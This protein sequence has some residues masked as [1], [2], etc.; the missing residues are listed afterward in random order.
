MTDYLDKLVSKLVNKET[1]VSYQ[2]EIIDFYKIF[3]KK[4]SKILI[5]KFVRPIPKSHAYYHRLGKEF[6]L[7]ISKKFAK[8]FLQV[9][10][11]L[12]ISD[13]IPHIIR[14]SAGCSLVCYLLGITDI[15]PIKYNIS[16][17]RFMHEG[18]EDLPDV[19]IDFPH[20]QRDDIYNK[21]FEQ[22]K[23]RVAR[24]SNHIYYKNKSA[25]KEAIR[26]KGYNKFLPRDVN[27]DKIFPDKEDQNDVLQ[28]AEELEG[29]FRCHSLHCGGIIIFDKEVPKEYY[30]KDFIIKEVSDKKI[31]GSQ[32]KL[33]K[34][35]VEDMNLIKIDI[36][37]NRGLSQ[38]WD[39]EKKEIIKY[40]Y[41]SKVYEYLHEGNNL[42]I[43]YSESRGLRKLFMEIKPKTIDDIACILALIRPAA[44]GGGQKKEFIKQCEFFIPQD[45]YDYVIYDDDA[46]RIISKLLNVD[47]GDADIY[48]K[49]FS[50]RNFKIKADFERKLRERNKD[51]SNEEVE[52]IMYKLSQLEDYSFCKSHAIS[53][54]LLV[55]ALAY[56]K[57]YNPKRFWLATLNNCNS[58]YR[59][60]VHYREAKAAGIRLSLGSPPWKLKDDKLY[61]KTMENKLKYDAISN[62]F[63]Y[64][65]WI[66]DDF[67]PG[68][69][70]RVESCIRT[71]SKK[72]ENYNYA[73]F[74]GIIGTYRT[75]IPQKGMKG[76]TLVEGEDISKTKKR[77]ITFVTLGYEDGKYVD[78][79]LW[80]NHN[81]HKIHCIE[82]EG[83][84]IDEKNQKNQWIS[85]SKFKYSYIS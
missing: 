48:R 8:V 21:I 6:K 60:W 9:R 15:D 52:K 41:D 23:G 75:Y 7:I 62:Y 32:I 18:R 28:K 46:I 10:D 66:N 3:G 64:G 22:W 85:A 43:T 70:L 54:A 12:E 17:A 50:K 72:K 19:D 73:Y 69:Y 34:D 67:L 83:E 79:V 44:S 47:E 16:L 55:Y 71:K 20:N 57:Y 56:Q 30:L 4:T 42:G 58:S 13:G 78:I 29:T 84:Y 39:I 45:Q 33:N 77:M 53:Y 49:G 38:L 24:I 74:R 35:E 59:K 31:M 1:N 2:Q 65:Y 40:E 68:M 36:L 11:I 14:G 51:M 25:L 80:G 81:L 26:Q 76:K 82:G 63:Q 5:N 61:S 27:I 37:S